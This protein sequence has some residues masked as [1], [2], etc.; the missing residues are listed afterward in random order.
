MAKS[1]LGILTSILRGL[2]A[3]IAFTIP[4]MAAFAA[5][6]VFLRIS[7]A[8]LT[9]LNQFLKVGAILVGVRVA[10]GRGGERGFITGMTIAML[11]MVIGYALY[12]F[13]GG[14]AFSVSSM[15][16]EILIGAAIGSIFGAILANLPAR[17]GRRR[18][19]TA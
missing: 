2:L 3:A 13:L 10:V 11:Y 15:L 17:S 19:K 4:F 7:D 8:L 1:R 5:L 12:V 6:A 14:S 9:A 18:T 16:G